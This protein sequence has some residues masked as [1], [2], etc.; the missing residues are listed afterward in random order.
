MKTNIIIAS[1]LFF[2]FGCTSKQNEPLTQQQ[3]EQIKKEVKL[4]LDSAF[5]RFEKLDMNGVLKYYSPEFVLVGDT[6][7][8]PYQSVSKA[9]IEF[10]NSVALL[11]FT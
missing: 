4:V 11:K 6:S 10:M 2:I 8:I 9:W 3:N 7:L 5:A 1:L